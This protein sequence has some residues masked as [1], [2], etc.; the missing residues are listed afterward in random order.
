MVFLDHCQFEEAKS[1]LDYYRVK[2]RLEA[3][4]LSKSTSDR[5]ADLMATLLGKAKLVPAKIISEW[6]KSALVSSLLEENNMLVD[7]RALIQKNREE[8]TRASG[9]HDLTPVIVN[10]VK[11]DL[12]TLQKSLEEIEARNVT[13][14]RSMLNQKSETLKKQL[15]LATQNA[16]LME[17]DILLALSN[18]ISQTAHSKSISAD[19]KETASDGKTPKAVWNWGKKVTIH[20]ESEEVWAD[21]MGNFRVPVKDQCRH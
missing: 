17:V 13:A 10:L 15:D 21:E 3:A 7:E 9:D 4:Y 20:L 14:L 6:L 12:Q 11:A 19:E 18:R 5:Y 8:M 1:Q 16:G 2:Y